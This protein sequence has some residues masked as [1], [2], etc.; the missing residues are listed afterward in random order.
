[1]T[2]TP[3]ESMYGKH[4]SS[5]KDRHDVKRVYARKTTQK[6]TNLKQAFVACGVICTSC[7]NMIIDEKWMLEN[8]SSRR[9]GSRGWNYEAERQEKFYLSQQQLEE[10][11]SSPPEE[12]KAKAKVKQEVEEGQLV[13]CDRCGYMGTEILV[14]K[15]SP[16]ATLFKIVHD[17]GTELRYGKYDS[18]QSWRYSR[19]KIKKEMADWTYKNYNICAPELETKVTLPRV[20]KQEEKPSHR[21]K[22]PSKAEIKE[23]S[24][25]GDLGMCCIC[26]KIIMK[27]TTVIPPFS[28]LP[29][30]IIE[31]YGQISDNVGIGQ[32]LYHPD[33]K[34][35]PYEVMKDYPSLPYACKQ[36]DERYFEQSYE[37]PERPHGTPLTEEAWNAV[38]IP[39]PS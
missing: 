25:Y 21:V 3:I 33:R 9:G 11:P 1:M 29:D 30:K 26:L 38:T 32:K 22:Q 19:K 14:M 28:N 24:K 23:M 7:G 31:K 37:N 5:C 39:Y 20:A 17:D 6:G 18:E 10:Q 2:N 12:K 15:L 16:H 35:M 36:C 34:L 27:G 8:K 13:K 4:R